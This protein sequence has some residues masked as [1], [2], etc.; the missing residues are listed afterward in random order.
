MDDD[1]LQLT[2]EQECAMAA[3]DTFMTDQK[4]RVFSL[5]GLAGTGK[6]FLLTHIAGQYKHA[7]ICSLTGKAASVIRRKTGLPACTLHSY[8]Y[9]LQEVETDRFLRH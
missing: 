7:A 1:T 3:F 6:T 8:F 4:A 5:Q 9:R 2:D